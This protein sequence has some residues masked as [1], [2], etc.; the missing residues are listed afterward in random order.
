MLFLSSLALSI[1]SFFYQKSRVLFGMMFFF[2]WV[3]FAFNYSNADY[4]MYERFYDVPINKKVFLKTEG[5]YSFLMFLGEIIGLNFQGFLI[6]VSA[7][8]LF[9]LFRFFFIFSKFPALALICFFWFFF[10]LQYVILRN[11]LSFVIVLQ[12]FIFILKNDKYCKWKF[13]RAYKKWF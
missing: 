10:P 6:V 12:G 4:N 11:F 3:L 5:G 9:L 1:I 8:T 2:M 13:S 7:I